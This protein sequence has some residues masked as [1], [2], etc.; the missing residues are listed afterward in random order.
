ML[1]RDED[2]QLQAA[3]EA[4][5]GG[6]ESEKEDVISVEAENDVDGG[7]L[8]EG[9]SSAGM[10]NKGITKREE[11]CAIEENS[12]LLSEQNAQYFSRFSGK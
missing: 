6:N 2:Q 8:V 9:D 10:S 5:S 4:V 7:S 1:F 3:A 11:P 12:A